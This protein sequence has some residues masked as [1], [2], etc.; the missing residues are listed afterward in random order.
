MKDDNGYSDSSASSYFSSKI[1]S[2]YN[3]IGTTSTII[4]AANAAAVKVRQ[5]KTGRKTGVLHNCHIYPAA[6]STNCDISEE[7]SN[8]TDTSNDTTD[9][10]VSTTESEKQDNDSK[11][12]DTSSCA[13]NSSVEDDFFDE[14]H[15]PPSP[16]HHCSGLDP[17]T[18]RQI[19]KVINL[20]RPRQTVVPSDYTTNLH[21]A[22]ITTDHKRKPPTKVTFNP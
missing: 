19:D 8:C 1:G 6:G 18:N 22:P 7:S 3:N 11:E 14:H 15:R 16:F 9:G 10:D 5:R 2:S 17:I 4:A 13:N 12:G 21:S 20:F